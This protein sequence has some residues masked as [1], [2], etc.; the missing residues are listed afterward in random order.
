MKVVRGGRV[1]MFAKVV[2]LVKMVRMVALIVK[3][4]GM[5]KSQALGG[6]IA[7]E[8]EVRPH[9]VETLAGLPLYRSVWTKVFT[10]LG[11]GE[12]TGMCLARDQ[13]W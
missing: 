8:L 13:R 6:K 11:G 9:T 1:V 10:P 2:T 7:I 5:I 4:A 12:V 3:I